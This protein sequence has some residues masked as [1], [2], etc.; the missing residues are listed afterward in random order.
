MVP[1]RN[2]GLKAM[3]M[4]FLVGEDEAVTWRGLRVMQAVQTLLHKVLHPCDLH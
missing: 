3:S 4:G 1:V 2:F